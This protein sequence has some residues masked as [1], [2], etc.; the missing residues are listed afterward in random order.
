MYAGDSQLTASQVLRTFHHDELYLFL[1]AAFTTLGLMS[2][3]FSFLQRKFDA[4]LF[5]LALFAILYGQRLWLQSDLLTL[6]VPPSPFFERLKESS[7]YLVPIPA[8]FY[9]AAAGFLGR[10]GRNIAIALMM[11]F[12]CIFAGTIWFGPKDSFE[13]VNRTIIVVSLIALTIQSLRRKQIDSDFVIVR[14]GI[15][16]FVAFALYNNISGSLG[17]FRKLEAFG[18]LGHFRNVEAIG[19]AFFLGTLGYVAAKRSLQRD[20]QFSEI[21]K[22]LEIARRIQTSILPRAYPE[23]DHFIVAA[24]YVP[25]TSVAG[26]FYDFLLTDPQQA[27]LLIADVSG[28]GV[29][30]ALI[31]S[32]VK[33]AAT[34]QRANA[35]DP[36]TLLSGMNRVL[37]GNTQEQFVTAAYVYLDAASATLRYSA[38]A[39][40][41]MLLL[42]DG[43]V[44]ELAENG[45]MLAAFSFATYSTVEYHLK[46]GDRIVLYTDGLLEAANATGEEFGPHRLSALLKD[47]A[48]LNPEAAADHIISSL[49][50]WSKSQN[51][52]L[53]VLICDYAGV[54]AA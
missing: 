5:W 12:L 4:M 1:G 22:E 42:R 54:Q 36:A 20:H 44:V 9:F 26:D 30:A 25:M 16:V 14:R 37:H 2:A 24:R 23:S 34:S 47:A 7:N 29:P 35:A 43:N 27:G 8:F 49:Q 18:S 51:D 15:V 50:T 6:M 38:A 13:S 19:F 17:Y 41:P 3:A 21:Q 31:A 39:H 10:Y 48:R 53:T 52:D 45:L 40:P 28:H 33:L 46:P 11:P 32:M